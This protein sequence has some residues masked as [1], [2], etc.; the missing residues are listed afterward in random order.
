VIASPW[1]APAW[2]KANQ[3]SDNFHRT[4]ALLPGDY[5]ALANYFVRFVRA[6]RE[7]GVT[8]DAVTPQN[9]PV[10]AADPGMELAGQ[11]QATFI[12]RYLGPAFSA[13]KLATRIYG[14]DMSWDLSALADALATGPAARYLTGISWHC[15]Y[16]SPTAMAQLHAVA[17]HLVQL[18][19]ECSPDVRRFSTADA[20]IGSLRNGASAVAL[21]NLVLD[22]AGGPVQPPNIRCPGC[23]GVATID[24]A[25]RRWHPGPTYYQLGQVSRFVA[26]GAVRIGATSFVHD[27]TDALDEYAL[28]PGLDAVAFANPDGEKVLITYNDSPSPI[29]FAVSWRGRVL[30]YREPSGAMTTFT[31]R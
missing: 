12:M 4:G 24:E 15:Y 6:Y 13:A 31:W 19:N 14:H 7:H 10:V 9:E 16:G 17:P 18:V 5:G 20:L 21:W 26:R 27:G 3:R 11:A 2:M 23:R 22:P 28:T 29:R 25:T 1:S 8:I 30:R